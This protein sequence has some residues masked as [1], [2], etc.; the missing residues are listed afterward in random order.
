[1]LRG[2][3]AKESWLVSNTLRESLLYK[4]RVSGL[5]FK[6]QSSGLKVQ[7]LRLWFRV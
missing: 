5:R 1:M 6:V 7:G 2:R 3:D 4:F